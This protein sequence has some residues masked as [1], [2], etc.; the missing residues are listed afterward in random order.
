MR[1]MMRRITVLFACAF[2]TVCLASCAL[3]GGAPKTFSK[4]GMSITLTSQ[5]VEKEYVTQTACYESPSVIVFA[6]K[7]E[8]S[9]A[10]GV[11]GW[12]LSQ[13]A[14][15]TISV[16]NLDCEYE[17]SESGYAYFEYEKELS[18]NQ[19]AYLATCYKG[20]DSFWLIQFACFTKNYKQYKEQMIKYAER[21]TFGTDA[22]LESGATK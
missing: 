10:P 13:Y 22:S 19:Y 9:M 11:S 5:F 14:S 21:V 2:I 12:S 3:F 8:F 16:N 20:E 7:E 1:S 4:A 6:L 15:T 18:G 17:I